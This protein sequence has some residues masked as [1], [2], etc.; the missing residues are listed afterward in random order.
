MN[1][2]KWLKKENAWM[3]VTIG[4]LLLM[5]LIGGSFF[6]KSHNQAKSDTD[7]LFLT[8]SKDIESSFEDEDAQILPQEIVVDL[9][10]AVNMPGIYLMSDGG[11]V[12]EV[13]EKA[14]GLREDADE[15]RV[16]LAALLKDEM[17][18]YIP[19]EGEMEGEEAIAAGIFE[20]NERDDGKVNINTATESELQQLSGVGPAKAGQ[21]IQY[22][23]QNGPFEK[24][25]DLKKVSG[26]GEKS[27]EQL[28]ESIKAQ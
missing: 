21:I 15:Q 17:V 22:R 10:G 11:R 6:M 20:L 3:L 18:L 24:I 23:E 26:I 2:I 9:K 13:I 7:W 28:R 5:V 16:N 19:T 27:F 8:E 4:C 12:Y 14:G 1:Q 25:E